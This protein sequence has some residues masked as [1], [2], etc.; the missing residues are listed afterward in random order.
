MKISQRA[1]DMCV[2]EEVTS[3]AYYTRHYQN[4]EWPGLSSGVT[5]AIGYD[6]GQCSRAKITA[7]WS[8][9][10]DQNMLLIMLSCAGITGVAAKTKCAE[11]KSKI[12]IP[13]AAAITVFA[14][15]DVPQWTSMVLRAVPGADKLTPSCLGMLFDLAYNRGYGGFNSTSDR[16][17]EMLAIRNDVG[18]KRLADVPGQ[19]T[20]M[21]RL[22]PNTAGLLRRCDH[23][24]ALWQIGVHE[25]PGPLVDAK[26]G[27][28]PVTNDLDV[29]LN[30]GAARTKPPI[31][32]TAQNSATG[33]I[34]A[35]TG[36][37]VKHVVSNGYS[38]ITIALV[39]ILGL[40]IASAVWV[41]WYRNRNPS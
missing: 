16:N 22:W 36:A 33:A 20:S 34:V 18:A 21:K 3:Q 39:V 27:T 5:V 38:W 1:F 6:L 28:T 40:S 26:V 8:A 25:L 4:P 14:N 41:T 13:W 11:V 24:I 7:D 12:T 30:A 19:I 17:R 9:L 37:A 31:T 32:S 35:G 15:R 2:A 29:P 23:R 10:V